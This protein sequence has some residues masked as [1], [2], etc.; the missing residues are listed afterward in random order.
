MLSL[1]LHPE[2][3]CVISRIEELDDVQTF[4]V[5]Q[6]H[7]EKAVPKRRREFLAG[8]TLARIAL[9]ELGCPPTPL[10]V[11]GRLPLWPEGYRGS[12]SHTLDLVGVA[13]TKGKL[14]PGLDLEPAGSLDQ[15]LADEVLS[16]AEQQQAAALGIDPTT[17]FCCKEA[18]FK[19]V[20]PMQREYFEFKEVNL[21]VRG[22]RF[23]ARS[24][25]SFGNLIQSGEGRFMDIAGHRLA[26]FSVPLS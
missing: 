16:A 26:F 12:I 9:D 8:R 4:A 15:D 24:Q 5:E 23:S 1:N 7:I 20:Y 21:E 3:V 25:L 6:A 18:L 17:L 2:L 19:A 13:V 22:I 11:D 10:P 14:S